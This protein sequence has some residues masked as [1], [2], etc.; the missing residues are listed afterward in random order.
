V[1]QLTASVPH[2]HAHRSILTVQPVYRF[3]RRVRSCLSALSRSNVLIGCFLAIGSLS[4]ADWRVL[5]VVCCAFRRLLRVSLGCAFH[6]CLRACTAVLAR[7]LCVRP[8]CL[9]RGVTLLLK[10]IPARLR[11]GR[12]F[13]SASAS[14]EPIVLRSAVLHSSREVDSSATTTAISLVGWTAVCCRKLWLL[15]SLCVV[16]RDSSFRHRRRFL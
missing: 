4:P 1:I 15:L 12:E 11:V 16:V 13:Q 14:H 10:Q 3:H 8:Q 7:L 5:C 6:R 9:W 2:V